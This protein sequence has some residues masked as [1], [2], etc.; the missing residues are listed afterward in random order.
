M[1]AAYREPT[2]AP[3]TEGYCLRTAVLSKTLR[4]AALSKTCGGGVGV[5]AN[6]GTGVDGGRVGDVVGVGGGAVWVTAGSDVTG[7]TVAV[8]AEADPHPVRT[9]TPSRAAAMQRAMTPSPRSQ[10][11]AARV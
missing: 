5:G 11:D 1:A 3:D 9:I 2:F 6:V 10:A 7:G 4:N 8:G